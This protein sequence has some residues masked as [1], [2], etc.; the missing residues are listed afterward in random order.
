M[1]GVFAAIGALALAVF[2]LSALSTQ[3]STFETYEGLASSGLAERGWVPAGIPRSARSIKESHDVS[4]N[5]GRAS[6][7]YDPKDV[8]TT[9]QTCKV[10]VE[11]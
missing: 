8:L 9:R 3:D 4:A 2:V 10:L 7:A 11:S 5:T 6:F 1:L